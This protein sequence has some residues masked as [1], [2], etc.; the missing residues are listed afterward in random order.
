MP[1]GNALVSWRLPKSL[2]QPAIYTN[3][4]TVEAK[5][6]VE[7]WRV[8]Y[9]KW[10]SDVLGIGCNWDTFFKFSHDIW[11]GPAVVLS[12]PSA[13]T[14]GAFAGTLANSSVVVS[15]LVPGTWHHV[16]LTANA[17]TCVLSV[18]GAAVVSGKCAAEK[19]LW[20]TNMDVVVGGFAGWVDDFAVSA[21]ARPTQVSWPNQP[22][23]SNML[24][25]CNA[26]GCPTTAVGF[27]SM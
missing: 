17:T 21:D 18:D 25:S 1:D 13:S 4:L 2:L 6:F 3:A 26:S 15:A 16:A 27:M 20:Q 22:G 8:G 24:A 14:T 19:L 9:S 23:L 7:A 10:N 5:V 11:Q 12:T